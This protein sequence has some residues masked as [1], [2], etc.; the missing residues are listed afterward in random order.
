MAASLNDRQR[1]VLPALSRATALV[2]VVDVA[3]ALDAAGAKETPLDQAMLLDEQWRP[4]LQG[5]GP[6]IAGAGSSA[7]R[8]VI[9]RYQPMLSL[10]G[11]IHESRGGVELGRTVAL[12]PG[13]LLSVT[14]TPRSLVSG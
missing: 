8:S 3:P 6:V 5:D 14:I 10:H 9:E 4:V 13:R 7:M 12:N 2:E 1:A 11:H